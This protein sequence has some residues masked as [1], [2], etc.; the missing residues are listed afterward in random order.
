MTITCTCP[1]CDRFCGFNDAHAG[2]QARCLNCSTHFIIPK[3][4]GQP[5]TP[6]PVAGE[7]PLAG[8]YRAVLLDNFKTFV[9][10][11]SVC[12]LTLCVALTGLH[13]FAGNKDFSFTMG[14]FRPPLLIGWFVTLCCTG[15][16]LWYCMEIINTTAIGN[17]FLPEISIGGGFTFIGQ[18]LKSIYLFIISFAVAILPGTVLAA[19]LEKL[20]ISNRSLNLVMVVLSLSMWP[21]IIC[22]LGSG[23]AGWNIFRYERLIRLIAKIP[24]PYLLTMS[25]WFIS[26]IG[27]FPTLGLFADQASGEPIKMITMLILR[28]LGIFCMLFAMRTLGLYARHYGSCLPHL[29]EPE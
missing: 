4:D 27:I 17:D 9:Q 21:M 20:G 7:E 18:A 12:G 1:K 15:Y 24:G 3:Q 26:L 10:K 14:A 25:I 19:L 13:F 6:V 5:A 8:F 29:F 28:L 11:E 2:R 16:L 23:A 22:L